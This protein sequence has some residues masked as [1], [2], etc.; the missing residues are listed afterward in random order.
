MYGIRAPYRPFMAAPRTP[1][2]AP[3]LVGMRLDSTF[4][5]SL[6]RL[7]WAQL[8]RMGVLVVLADLD[9][10]LPW[11][12]DA[13]S[14]LDDAQL[15]RA[16]RQRRDADRD[17]LALAYA[18]HRLVLGEAL[19]LA[20]AEVPLQRDASGCP[21]IAGGLAHTS[22]SHAGGMVAIAVAGSGPV[23]V[24]LEP[25]SRAPELPGIAERVCST[26][27]AT[28]LVRLP[29]QERAA[30]LLGLWVR[31]EAYLKAEGV[32]LEREMTEFGATDG[33]AI[34]SRTVPGHRIQVRQLDA[35]ADWVLA[36]ATPPDAPVHL[37]RLSPPG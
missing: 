4:V 27:E 32:G 5:R 28:Q 35:G 2:I 13:W 19:G 17:G 10:W 8:A 31:K 33:G 30:W 15:E 37:F 16:R 23:G 6:P 9:R 20:A 25:S 1:R 14:L 26:E 11:L 7:G 22:L 36:V 21:R 12:D 24:D 3:I 29:A 34:A 18:L